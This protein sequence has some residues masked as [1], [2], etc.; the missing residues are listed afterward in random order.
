M[1]HAGRIH[2]NGSG[3]CVIGIGL[4]QS[5]RRQNQHFMGIDDS[6]LVGFRTPQNDSVF[7]LFNDPDKQIGVGLF[8]WLFASVAL[9]VGHGTCDHQVVFLYILQIFFKFIVIIGPIFF[10]YQIGRNICSVHGVKPN[11]ALEACPCF[12][13][14]HAEH[15]YFFH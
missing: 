14:D 10:V 8:G 11:A 3:H 7:P 1:D 12:L 2:R 9:R 4:S 6:R 5:S 13:R 15:F